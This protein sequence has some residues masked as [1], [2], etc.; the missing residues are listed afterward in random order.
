LV[1]RGST[2]RLVKPKNISESGQTAVSPS[3]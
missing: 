2:V 1:D 3:H